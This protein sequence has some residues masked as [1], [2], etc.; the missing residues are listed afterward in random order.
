MSCFK[1]HKTGKKQ[2]LDAASIKQTPYK[3]KCVRLVKEVLFIINL[4]HK[5]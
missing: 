1:S 5:V 3:N 4:I 2:H